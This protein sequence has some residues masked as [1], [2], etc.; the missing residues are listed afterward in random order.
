MASP[1]LISLLACCPEPIPLSG[2]LDSLYAWLPWPLN[3]PLPGCAGSGLVRSRL[4]V[5]VAAAEACAPLAGR[6]LR[7]DAVL[8]E[9]GGGATCTYAEM[10]HNVQ[11]LLQR[12][13][14]G[15]WAPGG[16]LHC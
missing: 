7:G 2:R 1:Y 10:L 13:A 5:S 9:D 16:W 4:S 6:Q 15:P 3:A 8:V 14:L 11:V 12:L